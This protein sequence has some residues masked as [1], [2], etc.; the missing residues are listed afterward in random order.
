MYLSIYQSIHLFIIYS[1]IH[2]LIFVSQLYK[3]FQK[4]PPMLFPKSEEFSNK[5]EY[6]FFI[7]V[8][9]NLFPTF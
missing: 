2:L 1:S 6:F 8:N 4:K 9:C 7:I 3:M 5:F